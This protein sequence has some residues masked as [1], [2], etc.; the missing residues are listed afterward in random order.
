MLI[1]NHKYAL[2]VSTCLAAV[3]LAGAP[4]PVRAADQTAQASGI[5][6]VI[7]NARRT[8]ENLQRVPITV[9]AMT[10]AEVQRN[11]INSI[12][13]FE[14]HVPALS[15][16]CGRGGTTNAKLRGVPGVLAYWAEAPAPLGGGGALYFD[17]ENLQVL[18]GPQ[19]TLFGL[20]TNGGAVLFQP[21]KPKDE[22]SGY[23]QGT[24]GTYDRVGLEGVLN[25]P[26][27]DDKVLF[28]AGFQRNYRKGY[29]YDTAAGHDR[30]P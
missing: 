17:L 16:C 30:G 28:R 2:S 10:A 21:A 15:F 11:S 7:V 19:G 26:I 13:D 25:V 27:V 29:I 23:V 20:S 22:F 4:A 5:E 12:T 8:E 3:A 24:A 14:T 9:T 6:E 18:K 1:A